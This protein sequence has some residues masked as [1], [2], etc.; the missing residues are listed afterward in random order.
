M[1]NLLTWIAV[2][3]MLLCAVMLIAGIGVPA[4]WIGGIAVGIALVAVHGARGRTAT[5]H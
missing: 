3:L 5:R 1:S 2:P 4:L